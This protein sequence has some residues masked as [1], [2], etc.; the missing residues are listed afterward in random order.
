MENRLKN[1]LSDSI[2]IFMSF[3]LMFVNSFRDLFQRFILFLNFSSDIDR[4][5]GQGYDAYGGPGAD[6]IPLTGYVILHGVRMD[7]LRI[8][9][10]IFCMNFI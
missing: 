9:L 3:I 2:N 8:I 7:I 10:F 1:G 4:Y 6:N 5:Q